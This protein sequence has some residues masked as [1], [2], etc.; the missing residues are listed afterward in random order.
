MQMFLIVLYT[1]FRLNVIIVSESSSLL[2][3]SVYVICD[4]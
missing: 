1:Y 2:F 4:V 3:V